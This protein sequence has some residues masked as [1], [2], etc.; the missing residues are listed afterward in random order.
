MCDISDISDSNLGLRR[1]QVMICFNTNSSNLMWTF[2]CL[3]K[4]AYS[5]L[6]IAL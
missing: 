1:E 6:V 3:Y 4:A 5:R 2:F